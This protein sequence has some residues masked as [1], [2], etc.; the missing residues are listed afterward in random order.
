M[1]KSRIRL[2]DIASEAGVST[3][4]VSHVLNGSGKGSVS[5]GKDLSKHIREVAHR[6]NYRPHQAARAL[7]GS[8]IKVIGAITFG[9]M[10]PIKTRALAC[11]EVAACEK[12]YHVMSSRISA[13]R[14]A[15]EST[16]TAMLSHGING[17]LAFCES[18]EQ[19][20]QAISLGKEEEV[21]VIPVRL[22]GG[23]LPE[24]ISGIRTNISEGIELAFEYLHT[25]QRKVVL[26]QDGSEIAKT[27]KKK[28]PTLEVHHLSNFTP[29]FGDQILCDTD[30]TASK[31]IRANSNLTPGRDYK[32]IGWGNAQGCEYMNPR[33]TSIGLNLPEVVTAAVNSLTNED[34]VMI[35]TITPIIIKR[36]TTD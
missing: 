36:E 16:I 3:M 22:D 21:M 32:I 5:V 18:L 12:G 25:N 14:N 11:L 23:P 4:A 34:T 28:W 2:S 33:L 10:D 30:L 24:E 29:S 35:H 9:P 17:L 6:L 31:V 27:V 15:W 20:K 13:E 26:S 7:R 19:A 1:K 8:S